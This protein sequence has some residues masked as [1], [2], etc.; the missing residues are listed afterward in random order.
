MTQ[1]RTE[2]VV[3]SSST[4][5][6]TK[7]PLGILLAS[8]FL[9]AICIAIRYYWG[10]DAANA[11]PT[12]RSSGAASQSSN[13]SPRAGSTA[14]AKHGNR[15]SSAQTDD[16]SENGSGPVVPAVVATVNTKRILRADLERE[17]LRR[18][19]NE[20]MESMV[21]KHLIVQE[22]RRQGITVTRSEVDAEIERL[23]KQ[24]G[25]PVDQWLKMLKQERNVTPTQYANDI[26]WPTLALRKLAGGRLTIT[27]EE[28]EKE[29]ETQYGAAVRARLIAVSDLEKAKKVRAQAAAHPDDFGNLAKDTSE[30]APSASVK[31]VIQPIRKH[32][33]YKEI[34]DAV[35]NMA[36]G[37][38]SPVIQAG[39][40]Y[41]ILKREGLLPARKVSFDQVEPQLEQILRDRKMHSV[42]QDIH[43]QLQNGAK[44]EN[45]WNDPAKRAKM[46]G[47]AALVNGDQITLAT[48]SAECVARHGPEV[49]EGMISRQIIEQACQ[50]QGIAVTDQDL[51]REIARAA[52]NG[53]KSKPDGS[54]D[55]AA[56]LELVTKKQGVPLDV[57]RSDVVWPSVAMKKLVGN[58]IEI[59]D[60]DLRKGYEANYGPRVRCLAI[61][62]DNQR[63]AEQV[64][65]KARRN[66][67]S[68][69]FGDLAAEYSVE[70][71]SQALRGEVPPIKRHGGQPIVEEEA[72]KLKA[73]ELS[74]VLQVGDKFVILRCEGY[75]K[76]V[77]NVDFAKVRDDIYQDILEKKTRLAMAERLEKLQESATVD[78]YLEGTSHSGKPATSGTKIPTVRQVPGG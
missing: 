10:A 4:V 74:G 7:K 52:G 41:V 29:F 42:A 33:S 15:G 69:N 57:Y 50:K 72:F 67:T 8:L 56:W 73:G 14:D 11:D 40:Q 39:G 48:L 59:S 76:T 6:P 46:P 68:E 36:D 60:D 47:V 64:F 23:A 62:L 20:V 27:R 19:G 5:R 54:P 58:K 34:E 63:R 35:F 38:V 26:I 18:Y 61:V 66:N 53:V 75:T 32:G 37:D 43:H 65:E 16:S 30:D 55:V 17:A 9:V 71:S 44:I 31:G 2:C 78:N 13:P 12:D 25:I 70:P 49:L 1:N 45:V 77:A 3:E 51:D 24:F 22:C 21:N 28:L